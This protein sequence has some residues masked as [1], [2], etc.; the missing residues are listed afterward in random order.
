MYRRPR[1][2]IELGGISD[3][4]EYNSLCF[5]VGDPYALVSITVRTTQLPEKQLR[6]ACYQSLA[7]AYRFR[8][9]T[10]FYTVAKATD[11]L[12]NHG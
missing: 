4:Y 10:F 8:P 2:A 12:G 1:V 3:L 7:L 6:A 5:R 9:R 11:R